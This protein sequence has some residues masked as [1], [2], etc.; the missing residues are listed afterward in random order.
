MSFFAVHDASGNLV[1]T[2]T[3]VADEAT[4][5]KKNLTAKTFA[6]DAP[7][8]D[9]RWNRATRSF[10]LAIPTP[11]TLEDQLAADPEYTNL[12]ASEQTI[13]RILARA[14]GAT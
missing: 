1:S 11:P 2:G 12:P 8:V 5:A 14:L 13:V 6:G 10:D 4:L 7:P 9:K 3:Q